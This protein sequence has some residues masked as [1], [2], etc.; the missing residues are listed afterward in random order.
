MITGANCGFK[1]PISSMEAKI[2]HA[3]FAFPRK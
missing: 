1:E 3:L 2:V